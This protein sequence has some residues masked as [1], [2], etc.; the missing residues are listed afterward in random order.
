[1]TKKVKWGDYA[2]THVRFDEGGKQILIAK[3]LEVGKNL[4]NSIPLSRSV[5]VSLIKDGK[6]FTTA[7]INSELNL[8]GIGKPVHIF[9]IKG[10][11]FIRINPDEEEKDYL[12]N[13]PEF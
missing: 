12:G 10:K 11:E 7:T 4:T 8:W 6:T 2:I 5:V 13:L 1:M 9:P 3:V